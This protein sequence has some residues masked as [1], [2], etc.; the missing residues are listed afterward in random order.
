STTLPLVVFSRVRL[1]LN[2]EMN[3][4]ATLFITAVTIGVIAVNQMMLSRER[5]RERDMRQAFAPPAPCDSP[6]SGPAGGAPRAARAAAT[7][8]PLGAA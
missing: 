5:R 6:E 1:G 8:K 4:L 3:A 2:P 7:R